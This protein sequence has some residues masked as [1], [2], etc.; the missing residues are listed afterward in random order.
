MCYLVSGY[1]LVANYVSKLR[2]ICG[3]IYTT[4][5]IRCSSLNNYSI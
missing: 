2:F 5:F 1:S 3:S 4:Y